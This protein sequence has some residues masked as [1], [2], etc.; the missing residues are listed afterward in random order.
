MI[1]AYIHENGSISNK[2]A[3]ELT[4]FKDATIKKTFKRMVENGVIIPV[5]ERKSRRYV[6]SEK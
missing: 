5:G 6:L 3:C 2:E 4:G 1:L